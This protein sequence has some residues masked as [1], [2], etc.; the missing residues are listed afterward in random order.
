MAT[1]GIV[2]D[3]TFSFLGKVA[4][5]TGGRRGLGR[6]MVMGLAASGAKIA[7]VS[8]SADDN[9]L[10]QEVEAA[11]SE[12]LYLPANLADR[13]SRVGIIAAV[14]QHYGRLDILINNAGDQH[15]Q[16]AIE[17]DLRQW[18]KDFDLLVTA[19]FELS[20]QAAKVMAEQGGGKIIHIASISS[21]QGARNIVGYSTAKHAI[22]GLT[23]CLANEWAPLNINV[24]AVAPGMI[25]T[26]MAAHMTQ[27]PKKA[28]ELCGRIPAGRFGMPDDVVGPVLFLASD[29][30]RY[31]NGH[32]FLVDGGWLGR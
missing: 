5:V 14:V 24:N 23:K 31:V 6:A 18:D 11:G 15:R 10:R 28:L 4:L 3:C 2:M 29:A 17:Y 8:Q 20:Q 27:D 30:S 13:S 32:T 16:S 26:D 9:G 21:F 25:A 12:L 22:V 7:V 1:Q 19:V